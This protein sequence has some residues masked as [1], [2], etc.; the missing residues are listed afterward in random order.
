MNIRKFLKRFLITIV[1]LFLLICA[2]IGIALNFV[3][4]PEKITPEAVRLANE[5][6]HGQLKCESIELTFFSTFPRFGIK[7]KN[8][9]LLTPSH[10]Q[11]KNDTLARLSQ[12]TASFNARRLWAKKD[13]VIYDL[14]VDQPYV[15][16][17]VHSNGKT[18]WNIVRVDA[19]SEQSGDTASFHIEEIHL[20]RLHLN[21]A[22]L[23]YDD[24]ISKTHGK[25][26]HFDLELSAKDTEERIVLDTDAK[27]TG[28]H[29]SKDGY[30]FADKLRLAFDTDITYDK[31]T[32]RTDF[33]DSQVKLN[34]LDFVAQGHFRPQTGSD[35][36]H[37]DVEM[38][39]KVPSL[40]TLWAS[41][42]AHIIQKDGII[43]DGNAAINLISKGVYSKG[44]LPPTDITF[45]IA[46][47]QL[48]YRDF[49]GEIRQLQ[50]DMAAHLDFV[51]PSASHLEIHKLLLKGTGV[52]LNANGR[53]NSLLKSPDVSAKIKGDVDL[54]TIKRKFPVAKDIEV[55]GQAQLD[56]ETDLKTD[57]IMAGNYKNLRIRG[58]SSFS[59]LMVSDPKDGILLKTKKTDLVFGRKGDASQGKAFGKIDASDLTFQYKQQHDLALSSAHIKIRAK[60]EKDSVTGLGGEIDFTKLKYLGTDGLKCQIRK[61]HVSAK[62]GRNRRNKPA[63]ETTFTMDSAGVWQ[64][65]KFVGIRNGNY[66]LSVSKNREGKWMPRGT[67]EFNKLFAYMP[68]FPIP[69]RMDHSKIGINNRA[70]TLHNAHLFFGNSDITLSGQINNMLAKRT[71]DN[72]VNAKLTLNANFID[73]NQLM[74]VMNQQ[75]QA[76]PQ[77][78]EIAKA[79]S[80]KKRVGNKKTVFKIPA[81]ISLDF[82]SHVRKLHYGGMDL[83]DV[84]GLLKI[85]DGHL[86]LNHFEMTTLAARLTTSLHY[87]SVSD[88]RAKVEF[89][90]NLDDVEMANI[91]KIMPAMDSLFPVSKSFVGKAHLRMQGSALLNRRMDVVIPSVKSIAALQAHDV[92]VLDSKTFEDLAETF[93]FK[94]TSHQTIKNLNMEMIIE[95]SHM[96]VLPAL[97]EIDRYQLAVG[98]MQNLDMSYDYHVSVLKSPIPFKTGVDIKG[99]LDDYKIKLTKAKYKYYFS[100]KERHQEKADAEIVK[101]KK[102]ILAQLDLN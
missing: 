45:R 31:K 101:K 9:I 3:F 5:H 90:F 83:T 60:R 66:Q 62:L 15:R 94:E 86:R 63:I 22:R 79:G 48:K 89:D 51:D 26:D 32:R 20:R 7:V 73:A 97:V 8:A 18:N 4:T 65:H 68:E 33:N 1:S 50:T 16:A 96:E 30:L 55:H 29:L 56:M 49:P 14:T 84:K 44:K 17:I 12:A 21:D 74:E 11:G 77:E 85:A 38:H 6:L 80:G 70:I 95:K 23:V 100:D 71:P 35:A 64:N 52:D 92:M 75:N 57:E 10:I 27:A 91:S 53:V 81:N 42:P 59:D 98:G 43:L 19:T 93:F 78:K 40:K 2:V 58:N 72:K 69:L 39:L 54:T 28:I 47:G 67:V 46:D 61:A 102:D 76:D 13:L 88:R 25:V 87:T 99:N 41:V 37:T 36:I 24:Y 82:D 34:D